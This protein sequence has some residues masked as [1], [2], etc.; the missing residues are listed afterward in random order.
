MRNFYSMPSQIPND[1]K[2]FAD[3]CFGSMT[4]CKE[5]NTDACS[6]VNRRIVKYFINTIYLIININYNIKY[7]IIL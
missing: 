6:K 3:F 1:Q 4:S 5:G 7:K 2:A